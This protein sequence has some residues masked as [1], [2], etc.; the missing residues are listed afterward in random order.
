MAQKMDEAI[1]CYREALSM[2][3][4]YADAHSNLGVALHTTGDMRRALQSYKHAVALLP[5]HTNA[6]MNLASTQQVRIEAI[7]TSL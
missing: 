1:Y 4:K 2:N 7:L 6:A 5:T 3:P